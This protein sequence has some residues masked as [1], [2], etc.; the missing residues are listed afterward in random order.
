MDRILEE[1]RQAL[2]VPATLVVQQGGVTIYSR[3][4]GDSTAARSINIASASK[5]LSAAVV[6][7]VV[8]EGKLSLD[9][10]VDRYLPQFTGPSGKATIR[11]LFSM[12]SG[13]GTE[14]PDCVSNRR[15]TL[16]A[17]A[18][19]IARFPL[20]IAPGTGFIYGSTGMQVGARIA[21][22]VTGKTWATLFRERL[23]TPLG[24]TGT[25][26]SLLNQEDN[27]LIA[28]GYVSNAQDYQRFLNMILNGGVFD[29]RRVLSRRAVQDML[30]DQTGGVRIVYSP[31]TRYDDTRPSVGATR[32]G[33]GNWRQTVTGGVLEE[34]SSTGAFG[35]TPWV[36]FSRNLTG[37]LSVLS[38]NQLVFPYYLRMRDA[39]R[40]RVAPARLIARGVTNA[41]NYASGAVTPGEI[42]TVF[43]SN[44]GP[45]QAVVADFAGGKAPETLGGVRVTMGG[46]VAPLLLASQ[47]QLA[48]LVPFELAGRAAAEIR[49]NDIAPIVVPV[50]PT[51]PGVFT[52]TQDGRGT[53][54]AF[55]QPLAAG[56]ALV[57]YLTGA[58]QTQTTGQTGGIAGTTLKRVVAPVSVTIDGRVA[59]VLYAGTSPGSVEGLVQINVI[60]PTGVRSGAAPLRVIVGGV[61]ASGSPTVLLR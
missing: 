36:D 59:E 48:V 35:F 15:T 29:G 19:E 40:S 45:Q 7:S 49:I 1:M 43:G 51:K 24:M 41:A 27:P 23:L 2:G 6:M 31:Y 28:G 11:Q 18:A 37:T 5:W 56:E 21:E 25:R 16:E 34:S 33:I 26:V 44:L 32:Y 30:A 61:E 52:L 39:I 10:T 47:N 53:V 38:D 60:V 9:D 54:A 22:V 4:V 8:D 57:L 58:G 14:D 20:A 55:G 12:T 42:V 50:E 17:C 3:S 13:Y 46:V